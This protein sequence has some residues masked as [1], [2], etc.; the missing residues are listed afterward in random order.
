M[1][2]S[3][4]FR[5]LQARLLDHLRQ[6]VRRGEL[7]ERSLARLVR[8]S[9]PHM[10]N[11]LKG[12]RMLTADL[13]DRLLVALGIPLI[14]LLTQ[15]ELGG[16]GPPGGVEF[17]AVPVLQGRLGGGAAFP[18]PG[19]QPSRYF[20][21]ERLLAAAVSPAVVQLDGGETAMSPFLEPGDWVLLDRSPAVRRRPLFEH[22]YALAWKGRGYVAR[23]R[24]VGGALVLV[25]DNPRQSSDIPSQ[26]PR[27]GLD[28]LNLVKG[29]I[30]WLGREF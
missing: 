17:A 11:V 23:C 30:I 15:Q 3:L 2:G 22:A 7:S 26:I 12:S 9:Q 25:A 5:Q 8:Y 13:A 29:K 20:L 14:S 28:V 6:R 24:V 1:A 18:Q 16:L 27:T 21:P 19:P 10:H 4:G